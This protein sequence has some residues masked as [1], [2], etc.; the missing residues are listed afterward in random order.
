MEVQLECLTQDMMAKVLALETKYEEKVSILEEKIRQQDVKIIE[1]EAKLAQQEKQMVD[2]LT[3]QEAK[4]AKQEKQMLDGLTKQEAKLA[5]QEKQMVDGLTKQEAKLTSQE[6]RLRKEFKQ[7]NHALSKEL[8]VASASCTENIEK[9]NRHLQKVE[10]N[11]FFRIEIPINHGKNVLDWIVQLLSW[12]KAL[13]EMK[14]A[15]V[16]IETKERSIKLQCSCRPARQ[17]VEEAAEIV[18]SVIASLHKRVVTFPPER[19]EVLQYL[20]KNK[21]WLAAIKGEESFINIGM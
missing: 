7:Q 18:H 16:Q 1:Q 15:E 19:K 13:G 5:K 12:R 14:K 21:R 8:E 6:E 17:R 9:V 3:K 11:C 4:L 20:L 10:D 2:G